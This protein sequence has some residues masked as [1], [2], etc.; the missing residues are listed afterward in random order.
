MEGGQGSLPWLAKSTCA[1]QGT[2]PLVVLSPHTSS[3]PHQ[4]WAL[5]GKHGA[6][7]LLPPSAGIEQKLSAVGG[8]MNGWTGGGTE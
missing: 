7:A 2:V 1:G 6:R 3:L 8:W 4:A 5:E